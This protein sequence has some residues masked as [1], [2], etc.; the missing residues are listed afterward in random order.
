MGRAEIEAFR[1]SIE[2]AAEAVEAV[3]TSGLEPAMNLYNQKA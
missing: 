2:R 1:A 3:I